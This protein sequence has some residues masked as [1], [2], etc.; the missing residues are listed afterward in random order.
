MHSYSL[1]L[2]LI[3]PIFFLKKT[4]YFLFRSFNCLFC[5]INDFHIS[6]LQENSKGHTTC[7][8]CMCLDSLN[9][10]LFL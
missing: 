6:W 2:A 4:A 8:A 7:E 9:Q 3:K 5:G 10:S 1:N